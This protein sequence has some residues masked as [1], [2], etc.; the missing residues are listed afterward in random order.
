LAS[1]SIR[2][3]E[4]HVK[5]HEENPFLLYLSLYTVHTPIQPCR[6]HLEAFQAKAAKLPETS[7]PAFLPERNGQTRQRQD[8]PDYATMVHAMDENVG[9]VLEALEELDLSRKT[10][11]FFTSDNGGLSTLRKGRNAPTSNLPLRAGKGWCYEGGIRVPLI[12]RVPGVTEPGSTSGVPVISMDFYPTILELAGLPLRPAQH[13]DGMSLLPLLRGRKELGRRAIFW[14]YPH[15]HGS[16]WAPG[17]AIR[18]GDWKLVTFYEE[19]TSE[20]YR[21]S[22]DPGERNELSAEQ[23]AKKAELVDMLRELQKQTGAR[24]P[25]PNPRYSEKARE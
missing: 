16:T 14:H 25:E 2:F 23:P 3:L 13:V 21:L 18:A 12:I 19:G 22:D 11:V 15:Y 6:R 7:E 8:R 17:A 24:M 5:N 20:L 1:E 10:A 9:R 4:D